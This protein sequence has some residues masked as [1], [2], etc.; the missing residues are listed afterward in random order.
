MDPDPDADADPAIFV[1]DLQDVNK[2]ILYFFY[3]FSIF[4]FFI[5]KTI[6]FFTYY[7]LNVK[8]HHFSKKKSYRSHKTVGINVFLSSFA[9]C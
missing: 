7:F 8:L 5:F 1:S 9:L 6:C 2:K 4:L 3:C